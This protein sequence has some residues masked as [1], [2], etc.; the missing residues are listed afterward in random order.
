[1]LDRMSDLVLKY[2]RGE[3]KPPWRGEHRWWRYVTE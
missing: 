3:A 2:A 1:V